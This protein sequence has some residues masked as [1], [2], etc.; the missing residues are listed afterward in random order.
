M[1]VKYYSGI[2]SR[3][4]PDDILNLM[5]KIAAKLSTH[6]WRLRSGGAAGAD[7]AFE[8]G[9]A[10]TDTFYANS[11]TSEAI[12]LAS[13]VHPNWSA[14]NDYARQ[15]HGRNMM[16]V[17]GPYLDTPSTFVVC[18]TP[19]GQAIGG[20]ATG[21]KIAQQHNIPVRNLFDTEIQKQVRHWLNLPE[22]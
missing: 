14:C 6:N 18:W 16:I 5:E 7:S 9:S 11:A 8:R 3:K 1:V 21:I 4:T 19:K 10:Y 20:T 17:L 15:L 22:R 13:S 12:E 2:G